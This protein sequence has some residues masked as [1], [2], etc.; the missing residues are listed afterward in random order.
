MN[1]QANASSEPEL[2]RLMKRISESLKENS[3][4]INSIQSKVTMLGRRMEP[5]TSINCAPQ[6]LSETQ[7][8]INNLVDALSTS[9][10]EIH[11]QTLLLSDIKNHFNQ[12]I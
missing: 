9:L 6:S 10:G 7:P 3:D 8:A 11:G 2:T 4:L 12:L 5:A 1:T